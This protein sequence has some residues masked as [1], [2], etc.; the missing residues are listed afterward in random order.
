MKSDELRSH[1]IKAYDP[2]S[3]YFVDSETSDW[4]AVFW[5]ET[6]L[7][8]PLFERL[9][10]TSVVDLACGQGRHTAQFIE[11]AGQVTLVDANAQNIEICRKRFE[12]RPNVAC[13]ANSG[14]D[15]Q[16]IDSNSRSAVFSYD[17]MVHFEPQDVISYIF[18]ISRVLRPGGRALLHYSNMESNWRS[19]LDSPDWRNFFSESMMRAFGWR[20]GLI[21]EES[22]NFAWGACS[23]DAITLL[24]KD[25][26]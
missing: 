19:Y 20:A 17:A 23:R 10:L 18:E 13:L 15:L 12:G 3:L 16:G 26:A 25:H 6:S 4:V 2:D 5:D 11:R 9:D 21:V 22:N 24:R 14:R 7:F 8:R 1:L